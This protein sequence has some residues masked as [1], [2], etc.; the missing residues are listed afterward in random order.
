M[1]QAQDFLDESNALHA[2]VADLSDV[3]LERPTAFK[4]WTTN[5]IVRHLHVWNRAAY[6]S[7]TDGDAFQHFFA[8]VSDAIAGG[9]MRDFERRYLEG[10][11][12]GQMIETWR[13]FF[14]ETAERFADADPSMRVAWA[15]PSMSARS[16]ITARLME[17]WAHGQAVYDARGLVR[18]NTDRIGNIAILGVNTYGWTFQVNGEKPP[19]PKPFVRLTA[20]SGAS[21]TYGDD[22]DVERVEGSAEQFC[23]VVTQTR[24]VADTGLHVVGPN[25]TAWMAKAQCFAG[26]PETPPPPGARRTA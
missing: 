3:E 11:G 14:V 26:A 1:Q 17:T 16:S 5:D 4:S 24:N 12:G 23:Q 7:L 13:A 2:L 15:G 19:E 25:A 6:L 9:S 22:S 10:L 8:Q 18:E 21:W 20:P